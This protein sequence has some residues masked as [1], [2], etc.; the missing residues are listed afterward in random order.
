MHS[1]ATAYAEGWGTQKNLVEAA[2]W[3]GRAAVLG[4]VNDQFNLGVL[5]ER[6]MGVAQSLPDAYRWYAVAAA[7][8]DRE[9][10][11]RVAA[12]AP[13]L[14]PDDLAAA[15][16][17]ADSFKPWPLSLSANDPPALANLK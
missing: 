7:K 1:L 3:F 16:S 17:A 5:Y 11:S 8:G 4:S 2:R 6:G 13:M 9:S 12:I 15:R 14:S 10:Q